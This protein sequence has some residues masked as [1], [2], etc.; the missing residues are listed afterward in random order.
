MCMPQKWFPLSAT[1]QKLNLAGNLRRKVWW[2]NHPTEITNVWPCLTAKTYTMMPCQ[3]T[4]LHH[5]ASHDP[6]KNVICNDCL[7]YPP[8]YH[9]VKKPKLTEDILLW[10]CYLSNKK[11]LATGSSLQS[12]HN[13]YKNNQSTA[14]FLVHVSKMDTPYNN[15]GI[16]RYDIHESTYIS[17]VVCGRKSEQ[18]C[19]Y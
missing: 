13:M 3:C 17:K 15:W 6:K 8:T 7:H 9:A 10:I 1:N 19:V 14:R 12:A 11:P 5:N 18:A 4:F 16:L 2:C